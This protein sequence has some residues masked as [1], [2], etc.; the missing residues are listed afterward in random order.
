MSSKS[1]RN[2]SDRTLKILWG[3]A[4]GRCAVPTCRIELF[5]EAT[6]HDPI[7]TI[8]DI[9]HIEASSDAGPRAN[10]TKAK[11]ERDEYDN[12]I[13]LCLTCHRRLDGQ[14]NSNSIEF[15]RQ[16]RADHEAWVRNSLPE[17]GK[18]TTGW[19]VILLQGTHPL[20]AE[21]A[22]KALNPDFPSGDPL[23]LKADM[24]KETWDV[25]QKRMADEVAAILDAG[26]PFDFR[27]AIFPLAPISACLALGYCLTNRPRVRLFQY[28]ANDHSWAWP[29][30]M[31]PQEE[32]MV[33]GMPGSVRVAS[34]EVAICFHLSADIRDDAICDVGRSF[35]GEVHIT[36]PSPTL[37]WLRHDAQLK[38]L[39]RV[40]RDVFETCQSHFPNAEKWHLF[41]AGPAPGGVIVGQQINPTMCPPVQLY[42][43]RRGRKPAYRPS[44]VLG[45]ST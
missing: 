42:E 7:V 3:R 37:G 11:K 8:G 15:I 4:A 43:Y 25:I 23:V 26:D 17:R 28:Y 39:A 30:E 19:R 21:P 33:S 1:G 31:P 29:I 9:A 38:A 5:A 45:G 34:G 40:S 12:L 10:P 32:I 14:K 35:L 44:I 6:E 22:M 16:L 2:Y 18:S 36:A 24:N 13:L 27:L 41:F 20:D